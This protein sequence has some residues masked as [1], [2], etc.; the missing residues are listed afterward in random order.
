MSVYQ[1]GI[2]TQGTNLYPSGSG[3]NEKFTPDAGPGEIKDSKGGPTDFHGSSSDIGV[4]DTPG[5]NAPDEQRAGGMK[6]V[7]LEPNKG[8]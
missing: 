6:T 1:G 8:I 4:I 3:D 2:P 7:D 5:Y